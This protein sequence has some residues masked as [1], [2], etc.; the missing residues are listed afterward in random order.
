MLNNKQKKELDEL[1]TNLESKGFKEENK[2]SRLLILIK[3]FK[4][5]KSKEEIEDKYDEYKKEKDSDA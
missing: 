4:P 3:L 2:K 1:E 5:K